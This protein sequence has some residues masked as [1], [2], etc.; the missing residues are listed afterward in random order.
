VADE[1]SSYKALL[2]ILVDVGEETLGV[3]H[4]TI[5]HIETTIAALEEETHTRATLIRSTETTSLYRLDG[6][7]RTLYLFLAD[8]DYMRFSAILRRAPSKR[9]DVLLYALLQAHFIVYTCSQS[10]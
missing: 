2:Q 8:K 3:L 4:A 6:Q 1:A 9:E 10:L 7:P 5:V